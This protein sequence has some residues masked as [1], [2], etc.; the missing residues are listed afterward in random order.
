MDHRSRVTRPTRAPLA[1]LATTAAL[2]IVLAGCAPLVTQSPSEGMR[3]VNVQAG[4]GGERLML[5]G[6][7][8]VAYFTENRHRMGDPAHRSVH[9]GVTF[10][11]ASADHKARFDANPQAYLPQYGGYCA[12]G[13]VYAIPWGGD[14]DSWRIVDG[15]LYIFG[16]RGSK[17]AFELDVPGN[18]RL[19]DGYWKGEV[20]GA[21]AFFQ[22]TRRLVFKVP[23]YKS[24]EELAQ[25]VGARKP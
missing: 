15:K 6:H 1:R 21:N 14:A 11:F 2:A 19:A 3:P 9:K 23:H 20:E 25:M 12:N 8:V 22:R 17:A 5:G 7:D 18:I 10:Q 4:T 16:G 13:I 24:G